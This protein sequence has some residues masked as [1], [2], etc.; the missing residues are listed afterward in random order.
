MK[1]YT[2]F[3]SNTADNL[4]L[5]AGAF[6][7]NF[8]VG[9]DTYENAKATKL[10]GA[11]RGG[12]EFKASMTVRQIEIDGVKGRAKGLEVNDAWDVYIKATVLEVNKDTLVKALAS[13]KSG[14]SSVDT[15]YDEIVGN[16]DIELTDY[17]DNITWIGKVAGTDDPVMIQVFNALNTDGLTLTVADKNEATMQMT[18]YG[19]YDTTNLDNPPFKIWYPNT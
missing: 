2:G 7:V 17:I 11:T 14:A 1:T 19:H 10:L 13:A 4:L 9:T 12:G 8:E 15:K 18:F 3:N 5:D 16:N 6:F